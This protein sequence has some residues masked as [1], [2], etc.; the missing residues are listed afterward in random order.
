MPST[1]GV[2]FRLKYLKI[3][4]KNI[5]IALWDCAGQDKYRSIV[6]LYFKGIK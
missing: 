5:K 6:N 2:D 1:V 4:D 3:D